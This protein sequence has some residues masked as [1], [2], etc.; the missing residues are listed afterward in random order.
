MKSLK[1]SAII[2]LTGLVILSGLVSS[3][4]AADCG[5]TLFK[6]KE[7]E[8]KHN[9]E[10][11]GTETSC[12]VWTD[13]GY[14]WQCVN[15]A[16]RFFWA[17]GLD[18]K[19]QSIWQGNGEDYFGT[20]ERRGMKAYENANIMPPKANDILCY[21]PYG[22]GHVAIVTGV[23][24][25]SENRYRIDLVEQNWSETGAVSVYMDYDPVA[26]TY[27]V[28]DRGSYGVQGWIRIPYSCKLH[29]QNPAAPKQVHPGETHTFVV[30]YKNTLAPLLRL[31]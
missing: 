2:L 14:E 6:W 13:L 27:D 21:G 23:T 19:D 29:A 30:Y 24:L 9:G 26:E 8:G 17:A 1:L 20:A 28:E 22:V 15:Y 10:Y 7:V 31:F 5:E 25:V 3:V 18:S 4:F 12:G 11:H 16:R